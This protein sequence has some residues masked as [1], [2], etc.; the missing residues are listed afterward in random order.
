MKQIIGNNNSG[1][2][3]ELL[4]TAMEDSE[5]AV[6]I[7]DAADVNYLATIINQ[8]NASWRILVTSYDEFVS[9]RVQIEPGIDIYIDK[10]SKFLK[11]LKADIKGYTDIIDD[12]SIR[13]YKENNY[14]TYQREIMR[15]ADQ[16]KNVESLV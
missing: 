16:R 2:S 3:L 9:G 7:T 14:E 10:L 4:R 1:K 11:A 6:I 12:F 5:Q 15:T 13:M 8:M